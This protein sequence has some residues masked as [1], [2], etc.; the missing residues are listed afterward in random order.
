[1]KKVSF[2]CSPRVGSSNTD[3]IM[4]PLLEGAREPGAE[5]EE[6]YAR[7]LNVPLVASAGFW[8][9]DVFSP[10]PHA[11]ERCREAGLDGEGNQHMRSVGNTLVGFGEIMQTEPFLHFVE[12]FFDM[13]RASGRELVESGGLS[14][15]T[16]ER[17]AEPLFTHVNMDAEQAVKMA[18]TYFETVTDKLEEADD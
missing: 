18:N 12:P 3:K 6:F 10:P 11:L 2:S 9:E 14:Q 8:G 13:L 4:K 17:L 1:M 15:G 7:K 16:C 5:V